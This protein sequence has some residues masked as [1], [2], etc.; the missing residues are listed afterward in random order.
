MASKGRPQ[1]GAADILKKVLRI[2]L[3]QK[4]KRRRDFQSVDDCTM[5]VMANIRPNMLVL[6][7]KGYILEGKFVEP[8][9]CNIPIGA[10]GKVIDNNFPDKKAGVKW[11]G[12]YSDDVV[13]VCFRY[14]DL[15]TS[16]IADKT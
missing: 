1:K 9:K 6:R 14:L 15:F 7:K 13:Y 16:P 8:V 10:M 2:D 11:Y 5:Y 12:D 4:F 3:T